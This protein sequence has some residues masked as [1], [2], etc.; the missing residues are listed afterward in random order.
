MRLRGAARRYPARAAR[1]VSLLPDALRRTDR[2]T[3]GWTDSSRYPQPQTRRH[4]DTQIDRQTSEL[5]HGTGQFGACPLT[6]C[7]HRSQPHCGHNNHYHMTARVTRVP[8]LSCPISWDNSDFGWDNVR[9]TLLWDNLVPYCPILFPSEQAR[10]CPEVQV[11]SWERRHGPP[12][13]AMQQQEEQAR[14]RLG[15]LHC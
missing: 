7:L 14:A 9:T 3:D 6:T 4:T 5:S 8:D 2:R 1:A 11:E 10:R 15:S 13:D 12:D